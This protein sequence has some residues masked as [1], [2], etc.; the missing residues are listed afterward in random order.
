MIVQN[1]SGGVS[2]L[3]GELFNVDNGIRMT[4]VPYKG[5][6]PATAD[7]LGGQLH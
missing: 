5:T 2:H 4:H 6:A 1:V 7:L 3:A